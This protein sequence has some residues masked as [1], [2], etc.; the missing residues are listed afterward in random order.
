MT[1]F[2]QSAHLEIRSDLRSP[3]FLKALGGP[4]Q[5]ARRILG[6][7][8][9]PCQGVDVAKQ[10]R[11]FL[12]SGP[13]VRLLE[14]KADRPIEQSRRADRRAPAGHAFSETSARFAAV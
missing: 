4:Q 2:L 14:C 11:A 10:V 7:V 8:V 9:S 13:A 5:I 1:A 6:R 12:G 3:D